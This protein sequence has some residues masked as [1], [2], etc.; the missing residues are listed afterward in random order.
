MVIV[1]LILSG[2]TLGPLPARAQAPAARATAPLS[3]DF[4]PR[5]QETL[6]RARNELA[7]YYYGSRYTLDVLTG[8]VVGGL[9]GRL[10]FGGTSATI[11]GSAAGALVG[12]LWFFDRY[13]ETFLERQGWN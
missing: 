1:L 7:L 5:D 9:A 6:Y 10:L 13:A 4:N 12:I 11:T 8:V 3:R 2:L